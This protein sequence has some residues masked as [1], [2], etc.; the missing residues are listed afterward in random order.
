MANLSKAINKSFFDTVLPTYGNARQMPAPIW[1]EGQKMFL[2]D[3]YETAKGHRHYCG[4]RFCDRIAIVEKAALAYNWTYINSLELYAFDGNKMVLV[5][6]KDYELSTY[7]NE[8]LIRRDSEQMVRDVLKGIAKAN[9]S[10]T[11][12]EEIE[13]FAKELVGR[14]YQ[15]FLEED[16]NLR[17]TQQILPAI[18]K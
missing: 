14:C 1:D 13:T 4:V 2:C 7:R 6:K 15:S 12:D 18:E 8:E 17:L 5:Q 11:S 10:H 3:E 9:G 16:Y